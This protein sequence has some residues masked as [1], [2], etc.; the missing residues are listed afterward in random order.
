MCDKSL[1]P[2]LLPPDENQCPVPG[3]Q[4]ETAALGNCTAAALHSKVYLT[5]L[6]PQHSLKAGTGHER[7]SAFLLLI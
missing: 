4:N 6:Q 7:H 5:L 1:H 3:Q 2:P